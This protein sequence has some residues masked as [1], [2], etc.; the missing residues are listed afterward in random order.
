MP[1]R[2]TYRPGANTAL[3]GFFVLILLIAGLGS[4]HRSIG[5]GIALL[6]MAAA[7]LRPAATAVVVDARG[8]KVRNV[9]RTVRVPWSDITGFSVGK[10]KSF[11]YMLLVH[12]RSGPPIASFAVSGWV[13]KPES[14]PSRF[15]RS[16][17]DELNTYLAR[18][19]PDS[20]DA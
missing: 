2:R 8:V 16:T 3:F 6:V 13:N 12:R 19:R 1:S 18:A 17:A 15:T 11:P 10:A 7:C 4:I 20:T 5:E 9:F 14:R